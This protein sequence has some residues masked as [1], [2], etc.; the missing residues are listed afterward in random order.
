MSRTVL[1][2]RNAYAYGGAEK[3]IMVLARGFASRGWRPIVVTNVETLKT[4]C[5]ESGIETH[6]VTWIKDGS[7]NKR[8][9]ARQML[10][11]ISVFWDWLLLCLKYRPHTVVLE[12]KDDQ[13]FGSLAA[14]LVGARVYWRDHGGIS[15]DWIGKGFVG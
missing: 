2:C 14:R 1:L 10:K 5:R 8:F 3:A 12:S 4:L 7:G 11:G 9:F 6:S 13:M 15:R